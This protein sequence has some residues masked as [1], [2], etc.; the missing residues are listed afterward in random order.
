MFSEERAEVRA[1]SAVSLLEYCSGGTSL[2]PQAESRSGGSRSGK[3]R[4]TLERSGLVSNF[5]LV[6]FRE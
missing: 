6:T 1:G 3:S 5:N 4:R 2:P